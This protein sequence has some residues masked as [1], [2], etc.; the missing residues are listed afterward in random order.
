MN[1]FIGIGRL[2]RD[3]EVSVSQ[4]GTKVARYSLLQ[5]AA[6]NQRI[7][8]QTIIRSTM[9]LGPLTIRTE[10]YHFENTTICNLS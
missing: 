9:I 7:V 10:I 5:K 1:K 4:S 3:P 8:S 2:T 6:S